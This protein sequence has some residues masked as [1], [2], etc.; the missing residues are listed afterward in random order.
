MANPKAPLIP[1]LLKSLSEHKAAE[2]TPTQPGASLASKA[3]MPKVKP[4]TKPVRSTLSQTRTSNR[5][6]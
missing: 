4:S 6:K 1:N 3:P 2:A 5:G